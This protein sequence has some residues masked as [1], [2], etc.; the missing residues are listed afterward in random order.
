PSGLNDKV[1]PP[2]LMVSLSFP[3]ATSQTLMLTS[4]FPVCTPPAVTE[5]TE[6]M[7]TIPAPARRLPLGLKATARTSP[8]RPL[9]MR[10]PAQA[11]APAGFPARSAAGGYLQPAWVVFH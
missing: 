11:V 6:P 1:R 9:K 4:D 8:A 10:A 7:L 3:L 5:Y 2:P